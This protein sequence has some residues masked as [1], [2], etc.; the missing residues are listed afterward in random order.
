MLP[1][2]TQVGTT[3]ADAKRAAA[4]SFLLSHIDFSVMG[5]PAGLEC[6]SVRRKHIC[7]TPEAVSAQSGDKYLC[8]TVL[9]STVKDS[10]CESDR[11]GGGGDHHQLL[12]D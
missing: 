8:K 5:S 10:R 2:I 9:L 1:G 12:S 7:Q 4:L 11:N 3:G 6:S